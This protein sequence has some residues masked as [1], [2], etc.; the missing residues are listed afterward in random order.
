MSTT[1]NW[2]DIP[3]F[4]GRYQVSDLG[5]V[6]SLPFMQRYLLRNGREAFR[7]TRER[8]LKA[9]PQNSGYL[10]VHLYLD[11]KR[12]AA[13][14]HTLVACLFVPNPD[15]LPE[16]N[17]RDGVKTN[18]AAGNLEWSTRTGNLSHAVD[19]GLNATAVRVVHPATGEVF[20]SIAR[21]ARVARVSH[22]TV[23]ATWARA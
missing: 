20:P 11:N 18:C 6:R 3:G 15:D 14:V 17:H 8:I 9:H 7:R 21:A 1:E 23:A 22:R 16:V 19:T 13:T 12:T 5:R 2:Q 4:E 10:L